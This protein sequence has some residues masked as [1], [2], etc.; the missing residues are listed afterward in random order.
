MYSI[1]YV[2]DWPGSR[3]SLTVAAACAVVVAAAK[4]HQDQQQEQNV[5]IAS[6]K[7]HVANLLS[8]GL[9]CHHMTSAGIG[10]LFRK[11]KAAHVNP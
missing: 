5:I 2:H 9:H 11:I 10:A 8:F 6:A 3:V 4:Q 7:T 1:F